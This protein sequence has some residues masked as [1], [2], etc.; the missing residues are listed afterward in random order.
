LDNFLLN[1]LEAI[2]EIEDKVESF[3]ADS[4]IFQAALIS[5]LGNPM[6]HHQEQELGF[7]E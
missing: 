7:A 3:S 2:K 5:A 1:L 6:R 4:P